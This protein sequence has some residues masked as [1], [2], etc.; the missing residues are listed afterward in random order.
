M[1]A[2][3]QTDL[4]GMA[5]MASSVEA[6]SLDASVSPEASCTEKVMKVNPFMAGASGRQ[7]A[8]LSKEESRAMKRY[9]YQQQILCHPKAQSDVLSKIMAKIRDAGSEVCTV[10]EAQDRSKRTKLDK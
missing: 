5:S 6:C 10:R 2:F 3:V 1:C 4:K 9:S 8:R 7:E